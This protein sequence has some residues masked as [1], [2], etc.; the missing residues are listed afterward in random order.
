MPRNL[1]L[2]GRKK[3]CIESFSQKVAYRYVGGPFIACKRCQLDVPILALVFP[4]RRS[5]VKLCR[6][7]SGGQE[8]SNK[9][10]AAS[11]PYMTEIFFMLLW[12]LP[13]V[14][15]KIFTQLGVPVCY[16][17]QLMMGNPGYIFF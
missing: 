7:C 9:W 4:V 17:A 14:K 5:F 6:G 11:H 2:I 3:V 13:H 8:G 12:G 16:S 10:A 1:I 15:E